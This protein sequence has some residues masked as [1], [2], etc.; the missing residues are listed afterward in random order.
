M[1]LVI[2]KKDN[3]MQVY[4]TVVDVILNLQIR[5]ILKIVAGQLVMILNLKHG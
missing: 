2:R 4:Q 3:L 1:F 5:N